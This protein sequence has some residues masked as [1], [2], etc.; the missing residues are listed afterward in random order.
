M[1]NLVL[2]MTD[3]KCSSD[4]QVD[5]LKRQLEVK[6]VK[7]RREPEFKDIHLAYRLHLELRD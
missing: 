4:I 3:L 7:F 6:R 2:N 5:M 1:R